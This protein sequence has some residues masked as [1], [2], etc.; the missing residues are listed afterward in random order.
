[1]LPRG[2]EFEVTGKREEGG[3]TVYDMRLVGP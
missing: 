3:A 2:S 1:L